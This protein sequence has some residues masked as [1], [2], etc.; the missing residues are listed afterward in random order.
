MSK[1]KMNK[2]NKA[3]KPTGQPS[4]KPQ[5]PARTVQPATTPA[6]PSQG[7]TATGHVKWQTYA[8]VVGAVGVLLGIA[9]GVFV[10]IAGSEQG[11]R[12]TEA[13]AALKQ[14]L[15][16]QSFPIVEFE[17]YQWLTNSS[18]KLSC[19]SPADGVYMYIRN[20]STVPLHIDWFQHQ[21]LVGGKP[22]VLKEEKPKGRPDQGYTLPAGEHIA[23]AVIGDD[24]APLFAGLKGTET[25]PPLAFRVNV[26]YSTLVAKRCFELQTDIVVEDHCN[27]PLGQRRYSREGE[28]RGEISCPTGK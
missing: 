14:S 11:T 3:N 21:I 9:W 17:K 16:M 25:S 13:A 24:F 1:N 28:Q 12:T 4:P 10:Y 20:T 7:P 5:Q 19:S 8:A 2:P 6:P 18:G 23:N 15:D 22:Y 26:R 27:G